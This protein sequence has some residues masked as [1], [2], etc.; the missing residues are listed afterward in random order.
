[1]LLTHATT[2]LFCCC[3][4]RHTVFCSQS[5]PTY[6]TARRRLQSSLYTTTMRRE[7]FEPF[8]FFDE[9]LELQP[10]LGASDAFSV[11]L[12]LSA[13]C[14]PD[15]YILSIYWELACVEKPTS[16]LAPCLPALVLSK[17]TIILRLFRNNNLI[18]SEVVRVIRLYGKRIYYRR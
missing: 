9:Q 17:S 15:Y 12:P 7:V 3:F 18:N 13:Q 5:K 11:P 1:M 4:F 2:Y 14:S 8:E 6:L 16:G 10:A